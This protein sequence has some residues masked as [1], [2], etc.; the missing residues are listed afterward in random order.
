MDFSRENAARQQGLWPVAGV[1]EAGR[2][3]LAGPVVAAAVVLDPDA[4]PPG[5][6]DS[7]Q[8]SAARREA[9][10]EA[11]VCS[12][13]VGVASVSPS[14]IDVI[15][16]RQASLRAMV[17]AVGAL[18]VAVPL[19]LVDGRDAPPFPASI[20]ARPVIGGDALSLSIAAA[21]IVAKVMRDRMMTA[22]HAD[23]PRY[24]FE[25]HKGYGA[26]SHRDALMAFGPGPDHRRTFGTVR[27]LI[28][29]ED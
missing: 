22:L 9:L 6:N 10:F 25:G 27:R 28:T 11:I 12:A 3:P 13:R 24:G 4:I 2:G 26:Q 19:A 29:G 23:Q 14:E 18:P 21:S 5:L 16:I 15:N 1:D 7:K 17:Q 20:K 8:L